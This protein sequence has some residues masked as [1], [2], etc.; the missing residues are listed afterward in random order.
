M[1][2]FMAEDNIPNVLSGDNVNIIPDLYKQL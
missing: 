2:H 1:N